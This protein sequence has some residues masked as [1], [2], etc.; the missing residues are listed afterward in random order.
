MRY[1][2]KSQRHQGCDI[3]CLL[4]APNWGLSKV[5]AEY[6]WPYGAIDP[7]RNGT[8][9]DPDTNMLDPSRQ[10]RQWCKTG[11]SS[12]TTWPSTTQLGK[13]WL[14]L[15]WKYFLFRPKHCGPYQNLSCSCRGGSDSLSLAIMLLSGVAEASIH[16]YTFA[17]CHLWSYLLCSCTG[18]I[19][20]HLL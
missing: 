5:P 11:S 8:H 12:P 2:L 7:R 4:P 1:G 16:Y 3:C 17:L 15:A 13:L 14:E 10:T 20:F 19:T 6:F 9:P 18:W